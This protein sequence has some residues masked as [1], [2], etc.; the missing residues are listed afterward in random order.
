MSIIGWVI[1]VLLSLAEVRNYLT[2]RMREHMVVDT[3]LGEKLRIDVNITFHALTCNDVHLDVMDIAGD[4]QLNVEHEMMKQRLTKEGRVIG[5]PGVEI[6]GEGPLALALDLPA[7][8]CGS[9]YG[10]ETETKKYA[11]TDCFLRFTLAN[12]SPPC[13]ASADAATPATS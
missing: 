12:S 3:S 2:P 11:K 9:C 7:D 5:R 4:N 8:Y 13:R 6:I 10:A 1:I